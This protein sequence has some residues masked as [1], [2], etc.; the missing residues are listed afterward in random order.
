MKEIAEQCWL[1]KRAEC[2]LDVKPYFRI[3]ERIAEGSS[4]LEVVFSDAP[5]PPPDTGAYGFTTTNK[6]EVFFY[7]YRLRKEMEALLPRPPIYGSR[8]Q[9]L[10]S[11][12]GPRLMNRTPKSNSG[13]LQRRRLSDARRTHTSGVK[14]RKRIWITFVEGGA[15]GLGKRA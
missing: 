12:D 13:A 14:K 8:A 6:R 2:L 10:A 1:L 11:E 4:S 9:V 15:P 7:L 3:T 5:V